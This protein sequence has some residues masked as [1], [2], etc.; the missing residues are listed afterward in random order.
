VM[1]EYSCM[2]EAKGVSP[3]VAALATA[4]IWFGPLP[5]DWLAFQTEPLI[6]AVF[7]PP[8]ILTVA[9]TVI[10]W[11]YGWSSRATFGGVAGA[12]V[13][14]ALT[15]VTATLDGGR[16]PAAAMIC[17]TVFIVVATIVAWS[18]AGA[19]GRRLRSARVTVDAAP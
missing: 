4:F 2:T 12:L 19:F 18:L 14:V 8:F 17:G 16:S 7:A 10:V 3:L 1:C 11:R 6:V 5:I 15:I 9:A 13:G